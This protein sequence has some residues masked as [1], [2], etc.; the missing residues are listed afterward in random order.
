MSASQRTDGES[1]R[2]L[3]SWD[4]IGPWGLEGGRVAS[5]ALMAMCLEVDYR[6]ERVRPMW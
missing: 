2:Y 1:C 4:P 3:G 5:T 6:Y